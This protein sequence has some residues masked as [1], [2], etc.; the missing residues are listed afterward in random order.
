MKTSLLR[1]RPSAYLSAILA[2]LLEPVEAQTSFGGRSV[3]Y[4]L[5]GVA[6]ISPG[7]V[8]RRERS[9][10]GAE[11]RVVE[12]LSAEARADERLSVGRVLRFRGGD[13]RIAAVDV[14][15][16]GRAVLSLEL[17]R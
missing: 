1:Y 10:A 16:P 15:R 5:F 2:E 9:E 17:S 14:G 6:W 4:E 11:P 3:S 8:K 13:W 7:P 12:T